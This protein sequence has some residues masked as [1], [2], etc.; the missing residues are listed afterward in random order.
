[1]AAIDAARAFALS[2]PGV[3]EQPHHDMSSFRVA[4]KIFTTVTPDEA[5]LHVFI[6][7]PEISATVAEDPAAYEPLYWGKQLRGVRVVLAAA[8]ASRVRELL[9]EAW[10]RKAPKGLAGQ[11]DDPS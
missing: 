8:P 5:R 10:L 2:L 11:L 9:T 6:E 1:V 7:E 3:T 4:G